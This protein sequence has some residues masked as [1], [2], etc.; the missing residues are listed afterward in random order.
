MT[1]KIVVFGLV[2][3]FMLS[4]PAASFALRCGNNLISI[5]DLKPQVLLNCGEPKSKEVIGYVDRMD[6]GTRIRV[7]KIEEW[8]IAIDTYGTITYYSLVF[9]GNVLKEINPLK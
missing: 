6:N 2:L 1:R 7:M 3:I 4:I 5:G 8:V 9:E